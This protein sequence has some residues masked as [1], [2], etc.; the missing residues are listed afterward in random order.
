MNINAL[1]PIAVVFVVA[2]FTISIGSVIMTDVSE[3]FCDDTWI[4]TASPAVNSSVVN[5]TTDGNFGCC[6][7][8]NAS[9]TQDCDTWNGD[10]SS[11]TTSAGL[12]SLDE[13][14]SWGPTLAL[15][16]IAAIIIGVLVTYLAR[17]GTV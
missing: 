8:V 17:G 12:K 4:T 5:P 11:N 15:V 2:F 13:L 6:T 9:D 14:A 3:T 7:T 10:A 16:I 1:V